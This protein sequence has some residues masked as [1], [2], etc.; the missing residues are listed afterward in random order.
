MTPCQSVAVD[1]E[2][3]IRV[4][5]LNVRE[6]SKERE[7][8]KA[9]GDFQK[10][11]EKQQLEE[12]L[13]GYLDWITQAEDIDPENEDEGL[14]EEKPRNYT[15]NKVLLALFTGEMLLKMYSLGLQA[16][17]VSLFNRFDCFI[18]CGGILE[19][20]LVETKIM[21]PLGISVLRCVRLLRIFKITRYWNSLSNLV[22]SLLNSV[23]SIASLLL[24]LFLF[25]II[26]S[27]LGMQLFGGKFN[28][29]EMDTKR[30]T[31]DNFPQSLLTVFQILTGEDW[32]SVMYD[33]IKAYGG[34]SFPG[35]LVCIYFIILF[36]C[37]NYILLNVFLAIAVDNLADAESL[38]SAQKE[39]EEEKERK[40][41]ASSKKQPENEKQPV[42]QQK[43][44]E[45]IELKSITADGEVNTRIKMFLR[46]EPDTETKVKEKEEREGRDGGD[47]EEEPDMPVGPRPRPLSELHLKEKVVP[48]PQARAFFIFSHT[49]KFRIFCH[50]T[51]NHNIFTNLILFFIL[52][53]SISLA[54]EDPVRN[55]SFRNRELC[56]LCI[57]VA[58]LSEVHRPGTGQISVGGYTFYWSGCSDGCHTRGVAVALADWLVPMMSN[59][60]PFNEC[61]MRLRLRYSLGDLSVVP[62]YAPT[63]V[64]ETFY[65]QLHSVVDG[66]PRSDTPMV[67]GDFN[68]TTGSD[69]AG[70]EDSVSPHG[71]GDR[72]ES[73][74][75]LLDFVKSQGL[76]ITGS[77][78]RLLQNCRVYRIAQFVN[79]DH[80]FVVAILKIQHRS[81]RLPPTRKMSMDLARLQYQADR[82]GCNC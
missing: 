7:K 71:S 67:M 6:F 44:E 40:K 11:R 49:N 75:T 30:S 59:V 77:L 56:K 46:F 35:M 28:F 12:D 79:S 54:A 82:L 9:R 18:V 20:I 36:I 48:M 72:G 2:N 34:P 5:L 52:L 65:L 37:G 53:S 15:A 74:S 81:S 51:V 14:N 32:N 57:S 47:E 39:E 42:E 63:M 60:I 27:L 80:R 50:K 3:I 29:D 33:G 76:Q 73:G 61:I 43:N 45:K 58:A 13:K 64:R 62:V 68:M 4:V 26:F 1:P 8:A 21:S 10:L 78:L 55:D 69:R 31:F 22:A 16:Y 41:L 66:C 70:Y 38:T 23:R 24:L 25:I 19:T 17:F